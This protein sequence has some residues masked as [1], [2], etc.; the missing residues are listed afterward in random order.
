MILPN[1]DIS[2]MDVRNCLGYSS[3]DLGTLIAKAKEGGTGGYA[4]QIKE[5]G[6][7]S[8]KLGYL[9]D[10]SKPYWN[11]WSK[12]SPGRF[13]FYTDGSLKYRLRSNGS[14]DTINPYYRFALGDFRNYNSN[15]PEPSVKCTNAVNNVISYYQSTGKIQ[16]I[17]SVMTSEINWQEYL[18]INHFYLRIVG[19]RSGGETELAFIESPSYVNIN[20]SSTSYNGRY[21]LQGYSTYDYIRLELWLGYNT[22]SEV[23]N[24]CKVPFIDSHTVKLQQ[25]KEGVNAGNILWFYIYNTS[26]SIESIAIPDFE[27]KIP[28]SNKVMEFNQNSG[29]PNV[30]RYVFKFD[31]RINGDYYVD[32]PKYGTQTINGRYEVLAQG[33]IY[34]NDGTTKQVDYESLG[35]INLDTNASY[36]HFELQIPTSWASNR[37]DTGIIHLFL[38]LKD[39]P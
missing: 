6:F 21:E 30:G 3:T 7:S 29:T 16:I 27:T 38:R 20:G 24:K 5:N 22:G 13:E 36:N 35:Y 26:P 17:Y 37:Y 10:G 31:A 4:F 34:K 8:T 32:I 11:I 12:S 19:T 28:I 9:I 33:T 39:K 23:I 15:A 2:I 14:S 1:T 25:M 18:N